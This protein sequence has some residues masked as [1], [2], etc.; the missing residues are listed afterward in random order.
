MKPG[1]F[2]KVNIPVKVHHNA[3]LIPRSAIIKDKVK[4]RNAVFIIEGGVGKFREIELGL[5][6]G[7]IVEVINGLSEGEQVV[8]VGQHS[9]KDGETVQ[10]ASEW[11]E[12][13]SVAK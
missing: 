5:S 1:M 9:L 3:I 11:N 6:Q 4:N 10:V 13:K 7:N 2:A 8:T 12:F